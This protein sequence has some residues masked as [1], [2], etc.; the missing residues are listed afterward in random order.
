M[1]LNKLAYTALFTFLGFAT[2]AQTL[3]I[4]DTKLSQQGIIGQDLRTVLKIK[5]VCFV[6]LALTCIMLGHFMK[7]NNRKP[8]SNFVNIIFFIMF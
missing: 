2:H 6:F 8:I 7:K 1:Q 5:N 3:E 4:V